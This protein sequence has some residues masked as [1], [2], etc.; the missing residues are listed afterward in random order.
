MHPIIGESGLWPRGRDTFRDARF[1][2]LATIVLGG[3][4][5]CYIYSGGSVYAATIA[6]AIPVTLWR[7]CFGGERK[8][9]LGRFESV[10]QDEI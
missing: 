5:L 10:G 6:H 2:V 7:D 1:L 4:T 8:L 3:A 9:G